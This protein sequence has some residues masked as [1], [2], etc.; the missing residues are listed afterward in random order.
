MEGRLL[1]GRVR[2]GGDARQRF[3]DS[4][5]YGR[6][7]DGG[8]ID[9]APVE[10]AH[11]LFRGDLDAVLVDGDRLDFRGFLAWGSGDGLVRRFLVYRD[12]RSRGFYLQPVGSSVGDDTGDIDGSAP[13]SDFEVY[14]RGQ[15]RADGEVAFRVRVIGER[16]AVPVGELWPGV[17]AVVDEES[18][19][20]YLEVRE[21]DPAGSVEGG[22]LPAASDVELL[23]DRVILWDGPRALYADHFVGRPL[24]PDG[25][26]GTATGSVAGSAAGSAPG[27]VPLQCS[28]VE[29]AFLARAGAISL[30]P[31]R[32]RE[33]G[34]AVEGERFD[35]RLR[36]YA[37]LRTRGVV[38]KTGY[39]FGADFRTYSEFAGLE[40]LG[41][42]ELLVRVVPADHAFHPRD[43]ARDVRLA[44]GVRKTTVYAVVTE[45]ETGGK[46]DGGDDD[47]VRWIA[48]ERMTP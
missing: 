48:V 18:E 5:D 19:I 38:P 34:R 25:G 39:K 1:D 33:R 13:E 45:G 15:R 23:E 37:A 20:T 14:P 22:Q 43:L 26:G 27:T 31:E 40:D 10:A 8:A 12:L 42:S 35:R 2:V 11:L 6:P 9:L 4:R 24:E 28:L 7:V 32:V 41:H 3:H 44:H 17:L 30:D 16:T 47:A 21:A 29:A 46:E 36:V